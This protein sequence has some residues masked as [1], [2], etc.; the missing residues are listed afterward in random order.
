M[1]RINEINLPLFVGDY[2]DA[3][4]Q[5][6]EIVMWHVERATVGQ[7]QRKWFKINACEL[8]K[9]VNAHAKNTLCRSSGCCQFSLNDLNL[10]SFYI[11]AP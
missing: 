11:Q 9:F 10:G 6:D 8:A 5:C 7:K 3:A 2:N 4:A 1:K